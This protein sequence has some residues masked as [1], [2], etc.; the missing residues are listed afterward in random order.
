MA[1]ANR[2]LLAAHQG[3]IVSKVS[4]RTWS[5]KGSN[6]ILDELS[7]RGDIKSIDRWGFTAGSE[8]AGCLG[9]RWTLRSRC[10]CELAR[11]VAST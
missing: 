1:R 3:E 9:G 4:G 5:I 8:L 2:F 6:H 11:L 7:S 10:H